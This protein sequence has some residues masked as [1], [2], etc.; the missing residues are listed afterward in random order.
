MKKRSALI[1]VVLFIALILAGCS[2]NKAKK[3]ITDNIMKADKPEVETNEASQKIKEALKKSADINLMVSN[4]S[5]TAIDKST[6]EEIKTF[7]RRLNKEHQHAKKELKTVLIGQMLEYP[8]NANQSQQKVM[9][10]LQKLNGKA[11]DEKFINVIVEDHQKA[12]KAMNTINRNAEDIEVQ[13]L[14]KNMLPKLN[15]LL[16]QAKQIQIE[17]NQQTS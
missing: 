15:E 7:A 11:F 6:N 13:N 4:I 16:S 17:L 14:A 8:E 2:S 5:V 9:S 10:G 12:V 1:L 3:E